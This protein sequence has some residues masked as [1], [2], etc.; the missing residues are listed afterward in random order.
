M[1]YL[2]IEGKAQLERFGIP[3]NDS[4]LLDSDEV[5]EGLEFP[6]V[7]KGQILAGHRGQHGAV[8]V[9]RKPEDLVKIKKEIEAITI[10]GRKMEGV[11]ATG[12]LPIDEEY[13]LGLTLDTKERAMV[14]IF[15]PF[16]GMEI[17]DLA[18]N[19]PEKLMKLDCTEGFDEKAFREAAAKFA[20]P[21]AR[22]K[23]LVEFAA[24]LTGACFALDAT[25]IEINPL[26]VLK[27]GSMVAID[28]KLVI[29]DNSLNRQG[30]YVI[31]PR[32]SQQKSPQELE[33]AKYDLTYVEIDPEGNVGTMAGGA[34]IGMATMDTV[35]HYGGKVNNFLDLGGGVTSEKTYHAMKILLEND[36]TDCI[37]VNV[38]GG[39]N[40]CAEMA[41]GITAAYEEVGNGKLVVVKS[42]GFNQE[43]GWALYEKL[44]FLQ[45]K[46]GTTDEAAQKLLK[47][48]SERR[49][50]AGGDTVQ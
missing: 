3:V 7:L 29:D 31:L 49:K 21:E 37:L 13:Y 11:I 4:L 2:E 15:T 32:H 16:G 20:L 12:F 46:Y 43:D 28:C 19:S 42:R 38:F 14:M 6:C 22:M 1:D 26:A 5:P 27:D 9:V 44:G 40:N 48:E 34:G 39:I 41:K 25:T 24:K 35:R 45:T 18:A 23:E 36:E 30:D 33:A 50:Q 8:K 10:N 17:E 47:A